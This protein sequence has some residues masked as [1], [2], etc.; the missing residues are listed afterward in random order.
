MANSQTLLTLRKIL[1]VVQAADEKNFTLH[2]IN[3]ENSEKL[4][5]CQLSFRY[6]IVM[7]ILY[8]SIIKLKQYSYGIKVC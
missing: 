6:N 3:E 1:C 8:K 5:K 7:H 4:R 2:Q